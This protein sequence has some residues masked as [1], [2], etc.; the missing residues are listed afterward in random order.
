[1]GVA[2][3][4]KLRVSLGKP[5]VTY[6]GY[7]LGGPIMAPGGRGWNKRLCMTAIDQIP[8]SLVTIKSGKYSLGVSAKRTPS[9]EIFRRTAK[10]RH[11][12]TNKEGM[13]EVAKA[14]CRAGA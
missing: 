2:G 12:Q 8:F 3:L 6:R 14:G 4:Y 9:C 10:L 7:C 1:M 13:D 11:D 5:V